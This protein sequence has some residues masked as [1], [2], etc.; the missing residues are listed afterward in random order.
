MRKDLFKKPI[1]QYLFFGVCSLLFWLVYYYFGRQNL[2]FAAIMA[3][4]DTLQYMLGYYIVSSFLFPRFL[5]RR[6][7]RGFV[8]WF[9]ILILVNATIRVFTYQVTSAWFDLPFTIRIY[10]ILYVFTTVTFIL[11]A[12]S[13]VRLAVI[14]LESQK[15][16]EEIEKERV[17]SELEFLK[18]Q[19]NPHFFF[20][21]INTLY[22]T[23]HA[24]NEIARSILV[25][26]SDMMR[27]QLY[28]CG[29][30]RVR[31]DKEIQYI[32]HYID[33]QK[34]RS[35]NPVR[36]DLDIDQTLQFVSIP[37][38]LLAPLV[39]NAFKHVSKLQE[40]WI[41]IA[42]HKFEDGIIFKIQNSCDDEIQGAPSATGGIGLVNIRK[43]LQL[44]YESGFSLDID[45]KGNVF[46]VTLMIKK[47]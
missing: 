6:K 4:F 20:N 3:T 37:P 10:S 32:S 47:L 21:S 38:L 23:I 12:L 24:D 1:V 31:M 30:D 25:K 35:Q 43:R 34:L 19:L 17:T 11:C 29:A 28:E 36:I 14:W 18:G 5:L 22:G 42:L 7:I 39:E 13:G 9:I 33:F 27:Y 40:P 15:R 26:L 8:S 44:I 45:K 16:I 2:S 41:S 46:S